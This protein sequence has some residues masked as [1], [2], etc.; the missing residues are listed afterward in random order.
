MTRTG[1]I[2]A[3]LLLVA[4]LGACGAEDGGSLADMPMHDRSGRLTRPAAS[5]DE[6]DLMFMRDMVL[7]HWRAMQRAHD[8]VMKGVDPDLRDLA[9]ALRRS[10]ADVPCWDEPSGRSS[11]RSSSPRG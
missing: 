5:N 7:H 4:P 8:E 10:R 6:G 11:A 1:S 9:R 2:V 3:A